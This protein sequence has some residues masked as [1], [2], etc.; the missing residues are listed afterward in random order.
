MAGVREPLWATAPRISDLERG[1][2]WIVATRELAECQRR[3]TVGWSRRLVQRLELLDQRPHVLTH[4][5]LGEEDAD[6]AVRVDEEVC[7]Q[8]A[9]PAPM[10][11][12]WG[13]AVFTATPKP[14][15]VPSQKPGKKL[16]AVLHAAGTWSLVICCR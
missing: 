2:R 4:L 1:R 7:T 3:V 8:S 6:R 5:Y 13:P 12:C 10:R 11:P 14:H 16:S 9:R 15:P